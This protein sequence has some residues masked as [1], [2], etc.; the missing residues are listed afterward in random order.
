MV[1][2]NAYRWQF[3]DMNFIKHKII[4]D[5]KIEKMNYEKKK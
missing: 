2:F 1:F 5:K 4:K 3:T